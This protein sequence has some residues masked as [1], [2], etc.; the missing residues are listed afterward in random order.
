MT[1]IG[2]AGSTYHANIARSVDR[3]L[4]WQCAGAGCANSLSK[5][6]WARGSTVFANAGNASSLYRS[7][8]AGAT[9]ASTSNVG[10]VV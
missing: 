3:G 7:T 4:T 10:K 2:D 8:D 5:L 1:P 9:E 6:V